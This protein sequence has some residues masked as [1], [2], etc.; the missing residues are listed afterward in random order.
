MDLNV[1]FSRGIQR[2]IN[3]VFNIFVSVEIVAMQMD[4]L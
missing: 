4:I 1:T 2:Y 3:I